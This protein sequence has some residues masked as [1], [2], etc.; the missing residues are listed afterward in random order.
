MRIHLSDLMLMF[1]ILDDS[2]S[3]A[4]NLRVLLRDLPNIHRPIT[5]RKPEER[6]TRAGARADGALGDAGF[7]REA[8]PS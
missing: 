5:D 2:R 3:S 1:V 8:S 6:P 7:S 4:K